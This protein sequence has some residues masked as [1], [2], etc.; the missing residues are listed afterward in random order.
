VEWLIDALTSSWA[1]FKFIVI[2][3]Q[4]LNENAGGENHSMYPEERKKMLDLIA[5]EGITGVIFLTGDIHRSEVTVL[6]R[7]KNYPSVRIYSLAFNCGSYEQSLAKS[8]KN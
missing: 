7:E 3:T 4:F 8:G 5:K 1:P 2:G 6:E